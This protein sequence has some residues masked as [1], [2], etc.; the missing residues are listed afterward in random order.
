MSLRLRLKRIGM[1]KQPHYR[2][3][4]IERH[5]ARDGKELEVLGHFDPRKKENNLTINMERVKHWLSRGAQPSETVKS[6][7]E[8]VRLPSKEENPIK[9]EKPKSE[10][11]PATS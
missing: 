8:R 6:L 2:V 7:L 9:N 10:E 4:A 5:I 1:P 3:V 11:L